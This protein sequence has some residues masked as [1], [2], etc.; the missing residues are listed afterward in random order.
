MNM[1]HAYILEV[2]RRLDWIRYLIKFSINRNVV[3]NSLLKDSRKI[4]FVNFIVIH[5]Y[6]V[7]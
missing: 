3:F 6:F 2:A 4:F 1:S 5:T 7:P